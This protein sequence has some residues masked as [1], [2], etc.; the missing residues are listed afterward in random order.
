MGACSGPTAQAPP[1]SWS[2]PLGSSGPPGCA[3]C[4]GWQGGAGPALLYKAQ[5]LGLEKALRNEANIN[6]IRGNRSLKGDLLELIKQLI[7]Y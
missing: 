6:F 5:C 2:R 7:N 3:L 4:N 1:Y